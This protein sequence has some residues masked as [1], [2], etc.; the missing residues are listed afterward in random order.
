M[1]TG[2]LGLT[3]AVS[4]TVG[5]E[6][7]YFK[8]TVLLALVG[9]VAS[10]LW[11][12][13]RD[14]RNYERALAREAAARAVAEDRLVIARELHDAVSGSLGAITVRSA[15]AQRLETDTDGLR[16]ALRDIEETSREATDELRRMLG[17]LREDSGPSTPS[18]PSMPEDPE[19]RT[20]GWVLRADGDGGG[21]GAV[22]VG[23]VGGGAG[24]DLEHALAGAVG[25]ARRAGVTVEV[26]AVVEAGDGSRGVRGIRGAREAAGAQPSEAVEAVEAVARV[27]D[28]ALANTARHAGP[29]RARVVVRQEPSRLRIAVVDDG[30]VPGWEPRP[31]AGQ[32][33]RGLRERV[34]AVGGTL[35]AETGAARTA[36]PPGTLGIAGTA[37]TVGVPGAVDAPRAGFSVEVV[38]PLPSSMPLVSAQ[39]DR[40]EGTGGRPA[41]GAAVSTGA[42]SSPSPEYA[43]AGSR[44][45]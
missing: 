30:P 27:V 13:R 25:R 39:S 24:A 42:S 45:G 37:E 36:G 26:E 8:V 23:G 9:L 6:A 35:R 19:T 15:V 28:E 2:C 44:H 22:G 10:T 12:R 31:G 38:V 43:D 34:E 20:G 29:T 21:S 4:L 33:L 14:R 40:A 16:H 1:L 32:G 7:P 18:V 5:S 11:L 3:V 17:V 41:E